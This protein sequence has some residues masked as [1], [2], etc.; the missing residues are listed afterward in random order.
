VD[1]QTVA[2]PLRAC[3]PHKTQPRLHP[4]ANRVNHGARQCTAAAVSP[5]RPRP[6]LLQHYTSSDCPPTSE[7]T[8]TPPTHTPTHTLTTPSFPCCSSNPPAHHLPPRVQSRPR[9]GRQSH[10]TDEPNHIC[11]S[12]VS[13]ICVGIKKHRGNDKLDRAIPKSTSDSRRT[14]Y[15]KKAT[16]LFDLTEVPRQRD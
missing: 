7:S 1:T 13:S 14:L 5:G 12:C 8:P 9:L 15:A 3:T 2:R 11:R 16:K 6:G 10:T 4:C